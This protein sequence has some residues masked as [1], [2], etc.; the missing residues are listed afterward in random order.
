MHENYDDIKSRITEEPT[1]YDSNGTPRYGP[2]SPK[3]CPNIYSDKVA[4]LR[5]HCQA[6]QKH[7]NVE[8]HAGI[9]DRCSEHRPKTWHYGDPPRHE[10]P[11]A[12]ETMNCDDIAVLE[13]WCR[14]NSEWIRKPEF[15]GLVDG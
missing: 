5:I 11:G 15:E 9:W 4:L 14:E 8:M 10:C 13:F 6:C 7:F 2:F 1:W 12:G 3:G